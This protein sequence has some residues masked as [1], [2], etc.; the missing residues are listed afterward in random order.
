MDEIV[1]IN[2]LFGPLPAASA[3]LNVDS[4]LTLMQKHSVR[5]ACTLSTLGL[6]LDPTIGNSATKAA[7]VEHPE[8]MPV[9]L[10]TLGE[11]SA[12]GDVHVLAVKLSRFSF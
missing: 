8:L 2:T 7:C 3:D 10:T 5:A 6:L 9:A 12:I 11:R 1:D 4:L